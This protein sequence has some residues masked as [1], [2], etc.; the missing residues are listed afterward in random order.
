MF[1]VKSSEG[2]KTVGEDCVKN[3][4][5]NFDNYYRDTWGE[6][7]KVSVKDDQVMNRLENFLYFYKFYLVKSRVK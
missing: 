4:L 7:A 5:I 6:R 2:K 1:I 3:D